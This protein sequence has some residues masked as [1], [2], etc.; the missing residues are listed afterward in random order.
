MTRA[1]LIAYLS[2]RVVS[3]QQTGLPCRH[4]RRIVA[5][6]TGLSSMAVARLVDIEYEV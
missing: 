3:L 4:A 5:S 2:A 1:E 6:E